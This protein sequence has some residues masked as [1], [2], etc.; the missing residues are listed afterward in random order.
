MIGY[1]NK[2]PKASSQTSVLLGPGTEGTPAHP[3]GGTPIG[4]SFDVPY[5]AS[6]VIC[7][8]IAIVSVVGLAL[9]H[10]VFMDR[11]QIS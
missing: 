4:M 5:S 7:V 11:T 6:L 1:A 9:G 8:L 10:S 2:K 3:S